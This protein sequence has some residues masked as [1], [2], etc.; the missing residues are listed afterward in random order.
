MMDVVCTTNMPNCAACKNGRCVALWDTVFP[1][2]C[3]FYRTKDDNMTAMTESI[4]R[5]AVLGAYDLLTVYYGITQKT[6]AKL[7]NYEAAREW[8]NKKYGG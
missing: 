3:P 2:K 5:L 8:A 4:N 6:A 1:G 7:K